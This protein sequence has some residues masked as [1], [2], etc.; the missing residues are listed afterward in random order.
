MSMLDSRPIARVPGLGGRAWNLLRTFVT[1]EMTMPDL[2]TALIK[3]CRTCAK[4]CAHAR[5]CAHAHCRPEHVPCACAPSARRPYA[6]RELRVA[7]W[8]ELRPARVGLSPRAALRLV[9]RL[10]CIVCLPP[11]CL[12]PRVLTPRCPHSSCPR[13]RRP[14]SRCPR[15]AAS[16]VHFNFGVLYYTC[17]ITRSAFVPLIS[18]SRGQSSKK[19]V[20][21]LRDWRGCG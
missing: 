18:R 3:L 21:L 10:S 6:L 4:R 8:T 5:R 7:Y 20:S 9:V 2:R 17:I 19:R 11:R 12:R 14:H 1:S 13:S 16:H 15:P